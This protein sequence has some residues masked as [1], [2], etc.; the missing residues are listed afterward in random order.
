[1]STQSNDTMPIRKTVTVPVTPPRAFELFTARI[2]EWWP[3]ATHSVGD[4]QATSVVFGAGIGGAITESL[5]DGSTS[6]W[7]T[8]TGWDP[9]HGVAFTWHAGTPVTQATSVEVTFTPGEQGSTVVELVHSGWDNRPDGAGARAGY[10][11]G[12]NPVLGHYTKLAVK[13]GQ[14][15][16]A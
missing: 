4:G 9:P 1:V 13:S 3:L 12:W 6:V 16:R 2:G 7:G 15:A 14:P 8:I 5:A 10:D 11:T